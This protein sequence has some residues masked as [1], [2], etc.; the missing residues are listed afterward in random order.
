MS[1]IGRTII[2][3]DYNPPE[4]YDVDS[5]GRDMV[6]LQLDNGDE[7]YAQQDDEGNGP[8]VLMHRINDNIVRDEYIE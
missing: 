4:D 3:F 2:G 5:W 7:I 1:I 8:G 6:V